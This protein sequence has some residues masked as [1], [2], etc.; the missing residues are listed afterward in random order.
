M[1]EQGESVFSGEAYELGPYRT[2]SE[3][4]ENDTRQD[5][6]EPAAEL[7]ADIYFMV[8]QFDSQY[9]G[10]TGEAGIILPTRHIIPQGLQAPIRGGSA[11]GLI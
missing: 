7:D 9:A 2:L 4:R 8:G 5:R 6:D 11:S 3:K 1:I 10:L